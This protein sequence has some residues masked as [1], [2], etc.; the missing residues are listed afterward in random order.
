VS[1]ARDDYDAVPDFDDPA[2][3]PDM[4][5]VPLEVYEADAPRK[6]NSHV[7]PE[8][9]PFTV[10]ALDEVN[11]APAADI[12]QG[13]CGHGDL[14]AGVGPP[15]AGKTALGIHMGLSVAAGEMWFGLK[16]AG[17]PVLYC[18]PE[19]PGSVVMRAKAAKTRKFGDRRLP[20][21]IVTGTPQLGGDEMSL[22]D[23]ERLITTVREVESLEGTPVKL[24]QIDTLASCLGNGDE[25]S[26]GMI[27]LVTAT[28]HI[29][30]TIGCAVMLI[31]HPSKGDASGLRGHGS[32]AAAC[33]VILTI[34]VDE[35]SGVRTATLIKS[36]DSATG[37]QFCY[38]LEPV[39]LADPDSF[40]DPRTTIIVKPV[41]TQQRKPRPSGQRQQS[42]L[43]E[44]E[45][46]HR[47]GETFWDEATIRKAARD[48]GMKPASSVTGAYTGLLKAG[49]LVGSPGRL[50]L[51]FPPESQG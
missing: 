26:D 12:I 51:K 39:E 7:P 47:T 4:P 36:R 13:I 25:N 48:L 8:P 44:L 16:V 31:H 43:A 29:A 20:F 11:D 10:R 32:L 42:L 6:P 2:P 21:Y 24:V 49:Y 46:R 33:D 14:I 5:R 34:A 18:A 37:L 27:R 23:A 17:G 35:V 15:N 50:N 9:R 40:G 1:A 28:K 22:I 19:A 41:Q 3:P 45:R 38:T 30:T